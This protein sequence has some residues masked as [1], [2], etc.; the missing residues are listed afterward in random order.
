M[1][2]TLPD[3]KKSEGS[4]SEQQSYL[5]SGIH[6]NI[7]NIQTKLK[8]SQDGDINEQQARSCCRPDHTY[9]PISVEPTTIVD[10]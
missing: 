8:V 4:I 10:K 2:T 7:G 9:A 6:F 5:G 1:K 3:F